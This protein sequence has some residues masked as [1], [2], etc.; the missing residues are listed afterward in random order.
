MRGD[1]S[2]FS[3]LHLL[4]CKSTIGASCHRKGGASFIRTPQLHLGVSQSFPRSTLHDKALNRGDRSIDC[5]LLRPD[6][7]EVQKMER[8]ENNYEFRPTYH[9]CL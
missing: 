4:K 5:G 8:Y 1:Q 6:R 2:V 3:V 7:D 9:W